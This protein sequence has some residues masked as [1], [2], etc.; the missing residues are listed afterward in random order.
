MKNTIKLYKL[1]GSWVAQNND[2]KVVELFGT[3]CIPTAF[4]D[5]MPAD[6]VRQRIAEL[7]PDSEVIIL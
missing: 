6:E 3:D 1:G 5:K 4:G 2:P 7:N